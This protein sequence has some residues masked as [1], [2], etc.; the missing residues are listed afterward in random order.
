ME[1][2]NC[3]SFTWFT[4]QSS[5]VRLSLLFDEIFYLGILSRD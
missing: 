1:K 4:K 3:A 2:K 5:A